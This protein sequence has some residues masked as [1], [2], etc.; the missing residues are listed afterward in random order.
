MGID[1]RISRGSRE[2]LVLPVRNVLMCL[3]IAVLLRKAEIDDVDLVC[4]LAQAH[5]KVVWLDVAVNET[6]RVDE[7][8][9][10]QHLLRE[11]KNSFQAKLSRA[12]IEKILQARSQQVDHHHIVVALHTIPANV[13]QPNSSLQDLE[14]FGFVKKLGMLAFHALKLDGHLFSG[15]NVGPKKNISKG[16]APNLPAKAVLVPNAQLHVHLVTPDCWRTC[17]N[18]TYTV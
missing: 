3:G 7:F 5:E 16:A 11:H 15:G 12:K 17:E 1:A 4:L 10:A 6:L 18:K 8:D 14:Y 2:V 9:A 13:W